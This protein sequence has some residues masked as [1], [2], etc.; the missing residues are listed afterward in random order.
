MQKARTPFFLARQEETPNGDLPEGEF[1]RLYV[2]IPA[3]ELRR[4]SMTLT[5]Q[6]LLFPKKF[7]V[8][9]ELTQKRTPLSSTSGTMAR[10]SA[11]RRR[12]DPL[13]G[14]RSHRLCPAALEGQAPLSPDG[15]G[16]LVLSPDLMWLA[17]LD[18]LKNEK[19][20]DREKLQ[21]PAVGGYG[22]DVCP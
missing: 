13:P 10:W 11:W 12:R 15:R 14:S 20:L 9:C 19:T 22:P 7:M 21:G 6:G 4:Q 5:S 2:P 3:E 18:S 1:L 17:R 16:A 8:R